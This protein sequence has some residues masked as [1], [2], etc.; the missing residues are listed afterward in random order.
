MI[1]HTEQYNRVEKTF[2]E[3]KREYEIFRKNITYNN[4]VQLNNKIR[5]H[6]KAVTDLNTSINNI[7][8]K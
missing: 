1:N 3:F 4:R 8:L 2:E 5:E 7:F 6:R